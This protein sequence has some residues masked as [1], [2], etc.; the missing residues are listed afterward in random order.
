MGL[1]PGQAALF[2]LV[3]DL[4]EVYAGD[5]DTSRELTAAERQAKKDRESAAYDRLQDELVGSMIADELYYYEVR[6]S[7]EAKLVHL[8]DK[9]CPKA[10]RII[11][12]EDGGHERPLD[13]RPGQ[14]ADLREQC[15]GRAWEPWHQLADELRAR[16]FGAAEVERG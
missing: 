12:I 9:M 4:P 8:L 1:D 13:T 15:P 16:L 3:H 6:A 5:T 2:A 11:G 7:P 10:V 14:Q